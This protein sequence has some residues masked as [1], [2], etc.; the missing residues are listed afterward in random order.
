M[1]VSVVVYHHPED[2]LADVRDSIAGFPPSMQ[3]TLDPSKTEVLWRSREDMPR[4]C[5][6]ATI[7][8]SD[9]ALPE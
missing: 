5:A 4:T 6:L 3:R 8:D 2:S 9:A 1:T 7:T